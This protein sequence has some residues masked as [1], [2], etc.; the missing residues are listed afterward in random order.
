MKKIKGHIIGIAIFSFVALLLDFINYRSQ[1]NISRELIYLLLEFW[2]FYSF[3]FVLTAFSVKHITAF[4]KFVLT[5]FFSVGITF[6]L[7]YFRSSIARFYDVELFSSYTEFYI[8]SITLY[9]KISLYAV[10]YFYFERSLGKQK[11]IALAQQQHIKIENQKLEAENSVL[12]LQE[13]KTLLQTR[14]LES[15]INFLR[16]QINP[17]FLFNCLNFFYSE[18]L[19]VHP[20]LAEGIITLSQIMRYSLKDFSKAGGLA[21]LQE[22]LEHIQNVVKIHQMRFADALTVTLEV[23]GDA[24]DI[25]IAPMILITLVENVFKHGDL[26]N[27]DVPAAITCKIDH[28]KNHV[29]FATRNKK[30]KGNTTGLPESGMGL[31]NIRQRMYLL[32]KDN[33]CINVSDEGGVYNVLLEFPYLL[34]GQLAIEDLSL[35]KFSV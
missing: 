10:G 23:D 24:G 20:K 14:L 21:N 25:Q 30:K 12:Q 2:I 18:M 19:T 13:E 28:E 35:L 27:T 34:K 15:E 16:A 1:F 32:Y 22:E 33:F 29:I 6:L 26:H 8:A 31:A 4:L 5:L 9:I 7:N 3:F 11:Q 17:H